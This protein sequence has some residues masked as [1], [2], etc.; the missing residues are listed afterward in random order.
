MVRACP[1]RVLEGFPQ[2]T[3]SAAEPDR[4]AVR[5]DAEIAGHHVERPATQLDPPNQRG[6]FHSH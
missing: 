1:A 6:M 2:G 4:R 3:A 5:R